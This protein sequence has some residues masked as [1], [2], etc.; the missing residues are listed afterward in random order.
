MIEEPSPEEALVV[1][2]AAPAKAFVARLQDALRGEL[3]A[4]AYYL[5]AAEAFPGARRFQNLARAE[6]RHAKAVGQAIQML[7]GTPVTAHGHQ[8]VPPATA[9]DAENEGQKI[10]RQVIARF[11]AL[12]RDC[13]DAA[14][15]TLLEQLQAANY[16]HLRAMGG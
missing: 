5:A 10:E 14:I 7:G 11:E 3:Y 13:P 4:H 8:L 12:I 15:K 1:E 9:D 6:A 2:E 16:R